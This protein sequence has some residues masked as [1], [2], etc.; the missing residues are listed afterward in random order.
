MASRL[1]III[2]AINGSAGCLEEQYPGE[3]QETYNGRR[4]VLNSAHEVAVGAMASEGRNRL[5]AICRTDA[6]SSC[7]F[8]ASFSLFLPLPRN[9]FL[10]GTEIHS[11][12]ILERDAQVLE[13]EIR[14]HGIRP[15]FPASLS[16]SSRGIK[17]RSAYAS[18]RINGPKIGNVYFISL[19]PVSSI[20]HGNPCSLSYTLRWSL[21][22]L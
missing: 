6:A 14:V 17:L 7:V 1:I 11:L 18:S 22:A 8:P 12:Y 15:A 10:A 4:A 9:I 13:K 2:L 19:Y 20:V 3:K 5:L 21:P 16:P